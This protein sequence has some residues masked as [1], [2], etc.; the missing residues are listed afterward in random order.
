MKELQPFLMAVPF[1]AH[2]DHLAIES[3]HGG[4][5]SGCPVPFAVVRHG[6]TAA[7]LDR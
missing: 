7:L 2:A 1:V 4:K 3:V 5:R 6:S